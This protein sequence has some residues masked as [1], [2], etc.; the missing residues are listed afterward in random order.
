MFTQSHVPSSAVVFD[1]GMSARDVCAHDPPISRVP[2]A[3]A[4]SAK[5]ESMGGQESEVISGHGPHYSRR[6][7]SI[8]VG[9][10]SGKARGT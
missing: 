2:N 5:F 4:W 7:S 1:A 10:P 9:V 8:G 3:L 6:C